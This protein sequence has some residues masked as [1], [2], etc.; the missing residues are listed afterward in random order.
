VAY[1]NS[2]LRSTRKLLQTR[3]RHESGG[4]PTSGERMNAIVAMVQNIPNVS[5]W[6]THTH[7]HTHTHTHTHTHARARCVSIPR[8]VYQWRR[9][10]GCEKVGQRSAGLNPSTPWQDHMF[11]VPGSGLSP[12]SVETAWQWLEPYTI[13]G[14]FPIWQIWRCDPLNRRLA[15]RDWL[16]ASSNAKLFCNQGRVTWPAHAPLYQSSHCDGN[17]DDANLKGRLKSHSVNNARWIHFPNRGG[18]TWCYAR[19]CL[20]HL[21]YYW[22]LSWR[23]H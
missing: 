9:G 6:D 18:N 11:S 21:G 1:S 5:I 17:H 12:A 16:T 20:D 19:L 4:R 3:L 2:L 23:G 7:A 10:S 15:E 14:R 8:R 13:T 22:L